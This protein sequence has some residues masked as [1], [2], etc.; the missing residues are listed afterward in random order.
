MGFTTEAG[1]AILKAGSQ[2]AAGN[3]KD[4]EEQA[5][6]GIA[7]QQAKSEMASGAYNA[8]LA[9]KKAAMIQGQQVASI[10]ANNLQ[11][12]GTNAAVVA[13]TAGAQEANALQIQNNAL[14]RAWGFQVQ[15]ASDRFQGQLAKQQGILSGVGS[16]AGMGG[17]LFNQNENTI[18]EDVANVSSASFDP[19]VPAVP[20][21][22]S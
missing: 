22:T 19:G 13:S 21:M 1:G 16:L 20:G 10:G 18:D 6:A 14:R 5:N 12:A 3:T 7:D 11:Q 17:S 2:I 9:R 8:G 4:A 15:G